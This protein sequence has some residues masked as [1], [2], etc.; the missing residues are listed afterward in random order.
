MVIWSEHSY[1][2]KHC[3]GDR[4]GCHVG[5]KKPAEG[6]AEEE[7]GRLLLVD[8]V[9]LNR[10]EDK[11][12]LVAVHILLILNDSSFPVRSTETSLVDREYFIIVFGEALG[13]RARLLRV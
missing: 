9:L 1:S 5:G 6:A 13:K 2:G 10:L 12:P 3:A 7:D 4:S 8:F 11:K